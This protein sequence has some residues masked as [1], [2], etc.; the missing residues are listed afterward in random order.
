MNELS[1]LSRRIRELE[2][3][4]SRQKLEVEKS[5]RLD[6]LLMF[7]SNLNQSLLTIKDEQE[8]FQQVC[9]SLIE[10]IWYVELAW[11]GLV[12]KG[13]YQ[14]KP[15]AQSGFDDG[16][17]NSMRVTWD[18][19][20]YGK[21]PTGM[22]IKTGKPFV[23]ND[24]ENDPRYLPW[25]NEAQKRGYRSSAALPLKYKDEVIGALNI[26]SHRADVF[27]DEEIKFLMKIA[28]NIAI[29]IN[30]LRVEK[31]LQKSEQRFAQF[32][33]G[34]PVGVL[35]VD[36]E[37]KLVYASRKAR[38]LAAK[39]LKELDD[40]ACVEKFSELY[41]IFVAGT[42]QP[43]PIA[44]AP[45]YRALLGESSTVDDMEI[46]RP[47]GN[48]QI[49]VSGAPILNDRGQ[50]IYGVAVFK[51]ISERRR[52][53]EQL[54]S[55]EETVRSLLKAPLDT[56]VIIGL[57]GTILAINETG[58]K[59]F[60]R[61]P[62]D[63]TGVCIWDLLPHQLA[64]TRKEKVNEVIRSRSPVR[65]EDI[66]IGAN[67]EHTYYPIFDSRDNVN[68]VALFC[69][70][71]TERKQAEE[72]IRRLYTLLS[73]IRNV[74]QSLVRIR[75]EHELF[76]RICDTLIK[77][78]YIKAAWVAICDGSDPAMKP[79]AQAGLTDAKLSSLQVP[80]ECPEQSSEWADESVP[81][82]FVI[83]DMADDA[84][85]TPW[86]DEMLKQG[87]N[88]YISLPLMDEGK[89]FGALNILSDQRDAFG[90]E[91]MTFLTEVAEDIAFG[92]K[93]SRLE[94]RLEESEK[95]FA[96]FI[97][98]QPMAVFVMDRRGQLLYESKKAQKLFGKAISEL[99][100]LSKPEQLCEV[101]NAYIAGTS[102]KY[103]KEKMPMVR[104]LAG[105]PATED[106]I[107]IH[108]PDKV[109]P[110]EVSSS[111]VFD[112]NGEVLCAVCAARDITERKISEKELARERE[113]MAVT[114]RSIGEGVITADRQGKVLLINK[115]AEELT[116][117]PRAHAVGQKLEQVFNVMDA[118]SGQSYR[119][120]I[121]DMFKSG[122]IC[123]LPEN[124]VLVAG[125]GEKRRVS[126]S[127]SLL[128]D[129]EGK[130]NGAVI[131]FKPV[132]AK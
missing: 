93:R 15:V 39:G 17:L 4:E 70:D 88:S 87:Y 95:R 57:D 86:K 24:V 108:R 83:R 54:S 49:E 2:D 85:S 75:E 101:F 73:A 53:R 59:R 111:P 130:V 112:E 44:K 20:E 116:G 14:V 76:R 9:D 16:Y 18:D 35:V 132:P 45:I 22:C 123:E 81:P 51:D 19:S 65:Y 32:I 26:Y 48:V 71:I 117:R 60:S 105:M 125:S 89:V 40:E 80:W 84:K 50:V 118:D 38:E 68:R 100:P 103:P 63:L 27:G 107:E 115:A 30:D 110:L 10:E 28:G 47:E 102:Q 56:I 62:N 6:S 97:E 91:E 12:E 113:L 5:P 52:M 36:S 69:R 55:R 7:V 90:D 74:N 129:P 25:R 77:V 21:G 41:Q 46:H 11:I 127:C 109:V 43:Y 104:A 58:A 72:R 29:G 98:H 121:E 23:M 3:S 31:E 79:V 37:G 131:I 13:T 92:V 1:E 99:G 64:L 61:T 128:M 114:L 78:W 94:R 96:Q 126:A 67:L 66:R 82:P 119:E 33:E 124:I 122:K 106:D 42:D 120:R 8:L 34:L